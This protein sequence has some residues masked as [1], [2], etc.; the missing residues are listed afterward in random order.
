MSAGSLTPPTIKPRL[1]PCLY[2]QTHTHTYTYKY[3]PYISSES[4]GIKKFFIK[5]LK[6]NQSQMDT[7]V[8]FINFDSEFVHL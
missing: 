2:M 1:S 4:L 5:K 3:K 7:K 6:R 8:D